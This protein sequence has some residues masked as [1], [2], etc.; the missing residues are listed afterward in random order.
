M[1]R[2]DTRSLPVI[3]ASFI[4]HKVS[5]RTAAPVTRTISSEKLIGIGLEQS[6]SVLVVKETGC[7]KRPKPLTY[8]HSRQ[9][10]KTKERRRG[11]RQVHQAKNNT[12]GKTSTEGEHHCT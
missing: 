7:N 10:N 4:G 9:S 6:A 2:C 8:K 3:G 11:R 5:E 1:L 12:D